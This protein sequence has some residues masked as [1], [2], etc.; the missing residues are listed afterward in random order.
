MSRG[1]LESQYDDIKADSLEVVKIVLGVSVILVSLAGILSMLTDETIEVDVILVFGSLL[2]IS[3]L[4][5][6]YSVYVFTSLSIH[7]GRLS[8]YLSPH[9]LSI[10]LVTSVAMG[11]SG[12]IFFASGLVPV[13]TDASSSGPAV[14]G[15]LIFIFGLVVSA[16]YI[17]VF[18]KV[19]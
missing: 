2:L 18:Q 13:F 3:S 11:L 12:I 10:W 8:S 15:I 16:L 9:S 1:G 14:V 6:A 4:S 17:R 5:I 19:A 7:T